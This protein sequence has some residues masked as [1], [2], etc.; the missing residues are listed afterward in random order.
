ME[1]RSW[2][3]VQRKAS[4]QRLSRHKALRRV[5]AASRQMIDPARASLVSVRLVR[6]F[7]ALSP[8]LFGP[9]K[10]S[11]LETLHKRIDIRPQRCLH[12]RCS[13]R[14]M[15]VCLSF[16]KGMANANEVL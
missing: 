8:E 11:C 7:P 6:S 5:T 1:S 10:A 15:R 12:I 9:V 2:I 16:R 14:L 4:N 3:S 13:T